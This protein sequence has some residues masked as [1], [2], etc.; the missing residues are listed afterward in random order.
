MLSRQDIYTWPCEVDDL[1]RWVW[2]GLRQARLQ[3]RVGARCSSCFLQHHN[4]PGWE[5]QP[6]AILLWGQHV[7]KLEAC[8]QHVAVQILHSTS[9]RKPQHSTEETVHQNFL[10]HFAGRDGCCSWD[11]SNIPKFTNACTLETFVKR[12]VGWRGPIN[13]SLKSWL[14]L[15][16]LFPSAMGLDE[17][18]QTHPLELLLSIPSENT[19]SPAPP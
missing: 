12:Q 7:V 11:L 15:L 18:T 6:W 14:S 17:D 10:P 4:Q 2:R 13:T 5:A 19:L 16:G 8:G 1:N 9:V 3:P